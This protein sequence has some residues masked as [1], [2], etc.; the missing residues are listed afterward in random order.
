MRMPSS[1]HRS[2]GGFLALGSEEVARADDVELSQH[3]LR[4][5]RRRRRR[6]QPY[7]LVVAQVEIGRGQQ[8]LELLQRIDGLVRAG[9]P[10]ALSAQL[11]DGSIGELG[12]SLSAEAR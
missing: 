12:R 6:F 5:D 10:D 7:P 8:L 9:A 11:V 3:A 4:I 1:A 2:N